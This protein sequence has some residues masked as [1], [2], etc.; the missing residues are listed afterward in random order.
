MNNIVRVGIIGDFDEKRLSHKATNEAL[1]HCAD[2]LSMNIEIQWLPTENLEENINGKLCEFDALWC[3]PGSPYRSYIGAI[4]AIQ[5]ARE[6]N[7]PFI[8]T[9][10]GFQHTVMEYAKN[11]LGVIEVNHEEYNPDASSF[12]ITAL[13]CSLLGETRK[14][15]LKNGSIIQKIYG[16]D[17]IE[18]RYN[19][20]FGL[21]I[22]FQD[23]FD[24]SGFHVVGVDSNKEV[25]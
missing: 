22:K 23:T 20:K 5:F 6:N 19:C 13:S 4:N 16:E 15:Y 12:F 8:G 24:K 25:M 10:G 1:H 7:Y 17:E 14:I 18:E 11:V 2:S 9:C 21:N 3:S